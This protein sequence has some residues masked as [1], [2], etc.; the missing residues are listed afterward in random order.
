MDAPGALLERNEAWSEINNNLDCD[1]ICMFLHLEPDNIPLKVRKLPPF[2]ARS[3]FWI[4]AF[5]FLLLFFFF[6]RM[7][8]LVSRGETPE[9]ARA[10]EDDGLLVSIKEGGRE[11]EERE[12]QRALSS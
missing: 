8:R 1:E 2:L 4:R 12:G 10:G 11:R 9:A 5:F 6:S 3:R 7:T